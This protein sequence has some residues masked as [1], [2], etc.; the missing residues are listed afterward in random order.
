M[1]SSR[2]LTTWTQQLTPMEDGDYTN[3]QDGDGIWD[4]AAIIIGMHSDPKVTDDYANFDELH[5][6]FQEVIGIARPDDLHKY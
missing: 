2:T 6:H 5:A 3:D 4:T 1:R